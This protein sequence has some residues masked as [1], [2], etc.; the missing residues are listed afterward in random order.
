M[1]TI[2]GVIAELVFWLLLA[3]IFTFNLSIT[4]SNKDEQQQ[5]FDEVMEMLQKLIDKNKE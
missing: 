2:I 5:K 4:V 1:L 3:L